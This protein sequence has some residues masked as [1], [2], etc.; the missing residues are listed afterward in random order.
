MALTP[1]Q[2][3]ASIKSI[4]PSQIT[5]AKT[6]LVIP[7]TTTPTTSIMPQV[8]QVQPIQ[9]KQNIMSPSLD[10]QA[11]VQKEKDYKALATPE[12]KSKVIKMLQAG[13]PEATVREGFRQA[14]DRRLTQE[15]N[16]RGQE[17]KNYV[18]TPEMFQA[19]QN[20]GLKNVV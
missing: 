5:R 17:P 18:M 19:E 3:Q 20:Q 7:S 14:I 16:V 6:P 9:P 12:E 10:V 11:G 4:Q 2:I 13:I 8:T 1:A 15:N